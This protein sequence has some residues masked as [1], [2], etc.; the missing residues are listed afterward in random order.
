MNINLENGC[1]EYD[2]LMID[3]TNAFN[4]A[5]RL[6]ALKVLIEKFPEIYPYAYLMYSTPSRLLIKDGPKHYIILSKEGARQGDSLGTLMF[7]L[8]SQSFLITLSKIMTGKLTYDHQSDS[9]EKKAQ[10]DAP[11]ALA[12]AYVDDTKTKGPPDKTKAALWYVIKRGPSIGL[13][14]NPSKTKIK[15]GAHDIEDAKK[16][17]H[18]YM[19]I[20]KKVGN[21]KESNILIHPNSGGQPLLYGSE[22]LGIPIGSPEYIANWLNEKLAQL[23]ADWQVITSI[24]HKQSEWILLYYVLRSKVNYLLRA[25]HPTE[26]KLFAEKVDYLLKRALEDITGMT[27]NEHTTWNRARLPLSKGGLGI[28]FSSDQAITAYLGSVLDVTD[29]I[30]NNGFISKNWISY[31]L[32]AFLELQKIADIKL[33]DN[34]RESPI[35]K[36]HKWSSEYQESAKTQYKLSKTTIQKRQE[37]LITELRKLDSSAEIIHY[38]SASH[39]LGGASFLC[40]PMDDQSTFSNVEFETHIR[41]RLRLPVKQ[42]IVKSDDDAYGDSAFTDNTHQRL[43]LTRHNS[44]TTNIIDMAKSAGMSAIK[45]PTDLFDNCKRPDILFINS[46]IHNN[47]SV[48]FDVSICHPIVSI[49]QKDPAKIT[50]GQVAK[51]REDSKYRKYQ[52]EAAVRNIVFIPLILETC[53]FAT[54]LVDKLLKELARLIAERTSTNYSTVLQF[55]KIKIA[56]TMAKANASII[57]EHNE[58]Q[59]SINHAH[60]YRIDDQHMH[61][62][63]CLPVTKFCSQSQEE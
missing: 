59:L 38:L 23:E 55:W 35:E 20:L 41:L 50:Q 9:L 14:I 42:Q 25:L 56:T 43:W 11:K 18:E 28:G 1:E 31:N 61:Y 40:L 52:N 22:S 13:H 30:Q 32:K 10:S 58:N 54:E 33:S 53:G 12:M 36:Y 5:S 48:A 51:T 47:K 39:K 3:F 46:P 15:L 19:Q 2:E 62:D 34:Q 6:K 37:D 21:P 27:I 44:V 7:C 29:Y 60:T 45:E 16:H 57:I 63:N 4:T 26:T 49:E 24:Q 8:T 17:K